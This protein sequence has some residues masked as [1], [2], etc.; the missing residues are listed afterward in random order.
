MI[1]TVDDLLRYLEKMGRL[2]PSSGPVTSSSKATTSPG[3][4]PVGSECR[5]PCDS[6]DSP[7]A[8][9]SSIESDTCIS[10]S[11]SILGEALNEGSGTAVNT[12][13]SNRLTLAVSSGQPAQ[14][15]T[16]HCLQV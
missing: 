15:E 10:G 3:Q 4:S 7:F 16:M 6:G 8:S 2:K 12:E 9:R 11:E 1:N 13:N 14:E 5:G